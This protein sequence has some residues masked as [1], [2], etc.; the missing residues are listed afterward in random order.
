[1]AQAHDASWLLDDGNDAR[2]FRFTASLFQL[3]NGN[4]E[5]TALTLKERPAKKAVHAQP[6]MGT[7]GGRE[8]SF[9]RT[10]KG[11]NTGPKRMLKKMS[12]RHWG[13]VRPYG[14]EVL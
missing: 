12:L 3:F 13:F 7:A 4:V 6:G 10:G 8:R 9:A 1:M 2:A 5:M 14:I 11:D